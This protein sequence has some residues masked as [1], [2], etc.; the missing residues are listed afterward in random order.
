M[1]KTKSTR[2]RVSKSFDFIPRPNVVRAFEAGKEYD[3]LTAAMINRGQELGAIEEVT[4]QEEN[5][6]GET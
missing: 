1:P 2:W 5:T 3:G 4:S 6:N